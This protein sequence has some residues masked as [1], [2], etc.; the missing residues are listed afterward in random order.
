MFSWLFCCSTR[1]NQDGADKK[2][3]ENLIMMSRPKPTPEMRNSNPFLE[4]MDK[5]SEE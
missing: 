5:Q 4:S 3:L 1:E 2:H